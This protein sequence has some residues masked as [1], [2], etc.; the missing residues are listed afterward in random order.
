MTSQY[1]AAAGYPPQR[2]RI[3]VAV[4]WAFSIFSQNAVALMVATL[5]YGTIT[6]AL[7]VGLN[8]AVDAAPHTNMV[9]ISP[10]ND[11]AA[12]M[13]AYLSTPANIVRLVGAAVIVAIVAVM[14]SAYLSGILGIADGHRAPL[15]S[16]FKPR[17][18]GAAVGTQLLV[19]ALVAVGFAL[20]W[21]PGVVVTVWL[22]F[23]FVALIDGDLSP[24][25]ALRASRAISRGNF[26]T[27]LLVTLTF[28][29]LI[30]VGDVLLV[31]GLLVFAP[32][33]VLFLVYTYRFLS[34]GRAATP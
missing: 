26:W 27:A 5:V 1:P 18:I 31:V 24:L 32:V 22:M 12:S 9:D 11:A 19:G 3:R 15:G 34:A 21:L 17:R 20:C 16:F 14:Q 13:V 8:I 29:G 33:A 7:S 28:I 23:A 4:S 10:P 30:L 25:D 6:V 2:Y